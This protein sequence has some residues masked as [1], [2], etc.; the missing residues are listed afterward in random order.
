M[1]KPTQVPH[2]ALCAS[3]SYRLPDAANRRSDG[4]T[5]HQYAQRSEQRRIDSSNCCGEHNVAVTDRDCPHRAEVEG[6][7]ERGW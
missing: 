3:V 6:L 4:G 7:P 1:L 2:L 5:N